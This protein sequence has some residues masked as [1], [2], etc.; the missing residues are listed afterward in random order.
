LTLA[1][2]VAFRPFTCISSGISGRI[3]E[4]GTNTDA[5]ALIFRS[6]FAFRSV[7]LG[8]CSSS[9]AVRLTRPRFSLSPEPRLPLSVTRCL[10]GEGAEEIGVY[11]ERNDHLHQKPLMKWLEDGG[12]LSVHRPKRYPSLA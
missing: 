3:G 1:V 2:E 6:A 8:I 11:A 4:L 10:S 9:M 12:L 7:R 5:S